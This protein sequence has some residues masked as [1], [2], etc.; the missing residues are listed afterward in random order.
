MKKQKKDLQTPFT[1]FQDPPKTS[2][3]QRVSLRLFNPVTGKPKTIAL[4]T[5]TRTLE[6]RMGIKAVDSRR[7][8]V[9]SV[10]YA[11]VSKQPGSGRNKKKKASRR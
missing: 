10:N 6:V 4:D 5:M 2:K 7:S 3:P 11:W 1:G 8:V 9:D